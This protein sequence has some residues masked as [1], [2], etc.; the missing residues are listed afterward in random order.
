MI[1]VFCIACITFSRLRVTCIVSAGTAVDRNGLATLACCVPALHVQDPTAVT[2]YCCIC[3][4]LTFFFR[5]LFLADLC[6]AQN[7]VMT[8]M[9]AE[10]LAVVFAPGLM[11]SSGTQMSVELMHMENK[12]R[13]VVSL[14]L[15]VQQSVGWS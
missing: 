11:A 2:C 4:Y 14:I 6:R 8:R 5:L 15:A 9:T 7:S 1:L 10:N 3:L 12:K 13:V